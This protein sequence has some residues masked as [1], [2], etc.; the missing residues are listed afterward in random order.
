MRNTRQDFI[1]GQIFSF[2]DDHELQLVQKLIAL[3]ASEAVIMLL[4]PDRFT[5]QQLS[6]LRRGKTFVRL[7]AEL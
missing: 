3:G 2:R 5:K 4:V 6:V 7:G 1:R